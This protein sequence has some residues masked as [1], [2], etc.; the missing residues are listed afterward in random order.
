[1]STSQQPSTQAEERADVECV[2]VVVIGAGVT[3]LYSLYR[4][5]SKGL[6]VR[7]IDEAGGV[8][9]VWYW[10]RYPGCRFDSESATY[11]YSFSEELLEEW[12]WSERFSSQPENERY[13]NHVADKFDL[14]SDIYLNRRV[15]A[16]TYEQDTATWLVSCTDGF[17]IRAR[18]V[19]AAVGS[20]SAAYT[21][22]F[23][24]LDDFRGQWT[25][26]SRWPREG[27]DL[28]GK[29]VA[30]IGTGAT[31][32]QLIQTIA[33]HVGHLTVF[34]R[35]PNYCVPLN[36][37]AI[38][39]EE[40][41]AIREDYPNI[42]KLCAETPGGHPYLSDPRSAMSVSAEERRTQYE[43]LWQAPGFKKWL[44]NFSDIMQ[45]GPANEDYAEFVREKIRQRVHDPVIAEKLVPTNHLF[46]SKRV[47][48]ESNYYEVFN[49]D[50]VTLVDLR[51]TPI[52]RIVPNGIRTTNDTYELDVIAF[53]TGYDYITGPLN[54]IRFQGKDGM[55]L[56]DKF[57]DGARTYLGLIS[58]GFP[59]LFTVNIGP[60]GNFPR[61]MEPLI[62]WVADC[63]SYVLGNGYKSID[64]SQEAEDGWTNH[65]VEMAAVLLRARSD[66]SFFVG[67]NIP[68]KPR[69]LLTSPDSS[70]VLRAKREE[71]ARNGYSGFILE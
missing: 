47:P 46:G 48:C 8:G 16:A 45:P 54:Q 37:S 70:P 10:N 39:A 50:N 68:G 20:F 27:I 7:V 25:H 17:N 60:S 49:R 59:N 35:T 36:N 21:P 18:F 69:F 65:I 12:D 23:E 1:M 51:E 9:G 40:M 62:D 52:V 67:A 19:I 6:T 13:Y 71:S 28:A 44:A 15:S 2:D 33:E 22:P 53:A 41:E 3:G 64:A 66:S 58:A 32:I 56:K 55:T 38:S 43:E 42:F 24:G 11:G 34:Q 4:L 61:C 26:T 30:V 63:I 14:R 29:R 5:R 57:A 31:G